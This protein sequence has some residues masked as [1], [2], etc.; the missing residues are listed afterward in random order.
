MYYIQELLSLVG[1]IEDITKE[2][3]YVLNEFTDEKVGLK[4]SIGKDYHNCNELR[5][6]F[7]KIKK[8]GKMA[9]YLKIVI[10]HLGANIENFYIKMDEEL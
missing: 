2:E 9:Q 10:S 1:D 4:H 8:S 7:L 6:A 3:I 5:S